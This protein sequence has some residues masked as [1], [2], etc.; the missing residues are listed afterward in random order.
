MNW[1]K[2]CHKSNQNLIVIYDFDDTIACGTNDLQRFLNVGQNKPCVWLERFLKDY[3]KY[4][5][6]LYI[7]TARMHKTMGDCKVVIRE[8]LRDFGI[9]FPESHI[10]CTGF[11][12]SAQG[13]KSREIRKILDTQEVSRL[14]FIDDN[15]DNREAIGELSEEY[16]H[17]DFTVV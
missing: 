14:V 12:P 7:M 17:V 13:C 5:N 6:N 15:S 9:D 11:L 1:Y 8:F 4:G 16:P 3:Q 2:L 10:I